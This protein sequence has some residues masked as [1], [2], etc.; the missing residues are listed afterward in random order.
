MISG[1]LT[2][3]PGPQAALRVCGLL[4]SKIDELITGGRRIGCSGKNGR[5]CDFIDQRTPE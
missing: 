5:G 1:V 2:H 4:L 3:N